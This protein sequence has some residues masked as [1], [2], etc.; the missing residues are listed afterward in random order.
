MSRLR[1]PLQ[2]NKPRPPKSNDGSKLTYNVYWPEI[3]KYLLRNKK[4]QK[5]VKV[6]RSSRT[7]PCFSPAVTSI[8]PYSS[9]Q[10]NAATFLRI[11]AG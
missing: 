11:M 5:A 10:S 4:V 8:G 3:T 7:Q 2:L 1:N 9:E 6:T